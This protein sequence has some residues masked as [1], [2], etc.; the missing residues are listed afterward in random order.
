MA[1]LSVTRQ[2]RR[3]LFW[4][5]TRRGIAGATHCDA[6]GSLLLGVITVD[7]PSLEKRCR[8]A[9]SPVP[10]PAGVPAPNVGSASFTRFFKAGNISEGLILCGLCR[11]PCVF[12]AARADRC[13]RRVV[14]SHLERALLPR[15]ARLA[16]L[17]SPLHRFGR[18]THSATATS[19]LFR[20]VPA[21]K[22][23]VM[24]IAARPL[25]SRYLLDRQSHCHRSPK[26]PLL[27]PQI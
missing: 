25:Q 7:C 24:E 27:V 6:N 13:C 14:A 21:V 22:P 10:A 18:A 16:V 23:V 1:A 5:A 26:N 19:D 17:P 8:L 11:L 2:S 15:R 12:G 9:N 20:S 3:L 4:G